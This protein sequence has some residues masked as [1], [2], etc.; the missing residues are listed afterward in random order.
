M[1]LGQVQRMLHSNG[2]RH[3]RHGLVGGHHHHISKKA[4]RL[5]QRMNSLSLHPVVVR[6]QNK[7]S[8]IRLDR[9]STR[10]NSSHVRSSYAVFCLK[11]KSTKS[12]PPPPGDPP[13]P[14]QDPAHRRCSS[15]ASPPRAR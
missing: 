13:P 10:L 14:H 8:V 4:N 2:V 9:K 15:R 6:Y 7:G 3:A 11:K 1:H 12:P 5:N